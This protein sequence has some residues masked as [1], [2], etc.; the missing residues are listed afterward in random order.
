MKNFNVTNPI[1]LCLNCLIILFVLLGFTSIANAQYT[2]TTDDVVLDE[3]GYIVSCSYDFTENEIIIPETLDGQPV[4]GIINGLSSFD[5]VFANQNITSITFPDGF[6][7]IGDYSFYGNAITGLA[8]PEGVEYIGVSAFQSNDIT[9]LTLPSTLKTIAER[10]FYFNDL[11]EIELPIPPDNEYS[12]WTDSYGNEYNAGD[13]I[14]FNDASEYWA[15]IHYTLTDDDVTVVDGIL[16]GCSIDLTGLYLTVPSPLDGQIVT[17]IKGTSSSEGQIKG[18]F[19]NKGIRD[20]QLPSS[21]THIERF[22]FYENAIRS[23]SISKH[24]KSIGRAAFAKNLIKTVEFESDCQLRHIASQAFD[25]NYGI[26]F[27]LPEVVA[28][29]F[30]GWMSSDKTLYQPGDEIGSLTASYAANVPYTLTEGDVVVEDGIIQSTTY[31]ASNKFIIIPEVLDGQ[32]VKGIKELS[33][34][35]IFSHKG[36]FELTLPP[37]MEEICF[38]AFAWNNLSSIDLTHCKD[39]HTIDQHAFYVNSITNLVIPASVTEVGYSSFASNKLESV[40]FEED[41]H[42]N[43]IG[44]QAFASYSNA[45]DLEI[46]FPTPIKEGFTFKHWENWDYVTFNGGEKIPDLKREYMAVFTQNSTSVN[47][48]DSDVA[49]IFIQ[50]NQLTVNAVEP[51]NLEIFNVRGQLVHEETISPGLQ[52]LNIASFI[53]GVYIVKATDVNGN[54]SVKKIVKP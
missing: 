12:K 17:G 8:L 3:N 39:L 18:T 26:T 42:L 54:S 36:I 31:D 11:T 49:D 14:D 19:I 50:N 10:A 53:K 33:E 28:E 37:S 9:E 21:V 32:T 48:T 7:H 4:V 24:L 43:H 40:T 46:T 22:T 27:T 44:S 51:L 20:V 34:N 29:G 35:G 41:C 5:A 45:P 16:T 2:L 25:N 30:L 1:K 15:I 52:T 6:K 47:E 13:M 38:A 23:V